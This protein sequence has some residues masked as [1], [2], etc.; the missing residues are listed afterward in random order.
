MYCKI[1]PNLVALSA[2]EAQEKG[3]GSQL[4]R[5]SSVKIRDS[6][7]KVHAYHNFGNI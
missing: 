7:I 6:W 5:Q 2:N 3:V 1:S 4:D